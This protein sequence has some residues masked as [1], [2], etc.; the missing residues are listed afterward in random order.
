MIDEMR[1]IPIKVIS[2]TH[3]T[4]D[5]Y[6]FDV[7]NA[8]TV[9]KHARGQNKLFQNASH[10]LCFCNFAT[11]CFCTLKTLYLNHVIE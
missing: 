4:G 1:L 9:M 5:F 10:L 11:G 7:I 6:V 8:T 2:I 3:K